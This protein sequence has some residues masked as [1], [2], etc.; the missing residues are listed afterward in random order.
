MPTHSPTA[1]PCPPPPA[2]AAANANLTPAAAIAK[3]AARSSTK[4]L[5]APNGQP[6]KIP[7]AMDLDEGES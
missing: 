4:R 2:A 3:P 6:R 7:M 5:L 1:S